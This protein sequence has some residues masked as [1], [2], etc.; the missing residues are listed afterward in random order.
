V[1][2]S[3]LALGLAAFLLAG[4]SLPASAQ[5]AFGGEEDQE[6]EMMMR[7]RTEQNDFFRQMQE[8]IQNGVPV[9]TAAGECTYISSIFKAPPPKTVVLTF[10]DGPSTELTPQVLDILKKYGIKATFFNK[11]NQ[12]ESNLN[13][14]KRVKAE[15]HMVGN[16]S[17]SHPNFHQISQQD[18]V[19]EVTTTDGIL[20]NFLGKPKLFRYPYG[21]STC[22]TNALVKSMGYD[23]IVGWH[24]DSCD[25]AFSKTGSVDSKQAQI[26][27]VVPQNMSN[28]VGHVLTEVR[29]HNGGVVLLHEIHVRT[30]AN[31]EKIILGLKADGF[32][33]TNLDDP[34]M[35]AYFR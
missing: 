12:A 13:I 25:W 27:E 26:C 1:K 24:V 21:N 3:K 17:F 11:G 14:V 22:A 2:A 33:F 18:Q 19:G 7:A 9:D 15:G 23:G 34:R 29:R 20:K 16:H 30:V 4:S 6:T 28:F 35:A 5:I 10:D 8:N 31:L 32:K